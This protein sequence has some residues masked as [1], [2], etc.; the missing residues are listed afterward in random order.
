[1]VCFGGA[2]GARLGKVRQVAEQ[3]GE[4]RLGVAGF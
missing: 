3:N 1:M 4:V 2:G